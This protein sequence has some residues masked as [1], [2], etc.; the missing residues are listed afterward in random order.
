MTPG[1]DVKRYFQGMRGCIWS[2]ER[3]YRLRKIRHNVENQFL[4]D[5]QMRNRPELLIRSNLF[6]VIFSRP[7]GSTIV[8]ES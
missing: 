2:S 6:S 4:I 8:P 3:S 7:R 5:G 1:D